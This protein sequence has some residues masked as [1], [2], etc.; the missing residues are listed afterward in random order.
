MR[1]V[2]VCLTDDP[3]DPPGEGGHGGSHRFIC[4]LGRHLVR[5][6]IR[7]TF[8]TRLDHPQKPD[9]D[10]LGS[11]ADLHR[12]AVGPV[13]VLPYYDVAAHLTSLASRLAELAGGWSL[14]D[15]D[16]VVS[17]NWI[18]GEA[19][20]RCE[21]F[22]CPHIHYVLALGR[23]RLQR[24]EDTDKVSELWLAC[25]DRLFRHASFLVVPARSEREDM[26][27]LYEGI[28]PR[29]VSVVPNGLDLGTFQPRPRP[30][31]DFVRGAAD[32]F[33]QGAVDVVHK[34][35]DP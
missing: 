23:A 21:A 20:L 19:V 9:R 28:D 35:G 5:Q 32:G 15:E 17:Y 14:S 24:G 10:V 22:P 26:L 1:V 3:F 4:D 18:S 6:G 33:R 2:V 16:R 11:Y 8:V 30:L 25:E 27:A 31:A 7:V 29:N 13:E 12:L 34:P